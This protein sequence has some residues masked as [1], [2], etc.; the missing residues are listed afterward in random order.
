MQGIEADLVSFRDIKALKS[1][2]RHYRI[3]EPHDE[4]DPFERPLVAELQAGLWK[5]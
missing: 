3:D 1:S 2:L 4:L 5:R